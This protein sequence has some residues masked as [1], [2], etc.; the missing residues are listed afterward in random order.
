MNKGRFEAFSDGVFAIAITLLV[1]EFRLPEPVAGRPEGGLVNALLALW[2][3]YL[4]FFASF[5]TIGI[6]W[7]NHHGLFHSV[8]RVTH[9]I[10]LYNLLLLMLVAFVPFPT[11][12]LARYGPSQSA[13]VFYGFS[14]LLIA[15]AYR[16]LWY[17]VT[18]PPNGRHTFAGFVSAWT[19]W[20]AVGHVA[21]VAGIAIAFVSPIVSLCIFALVAIYYALSGTVRSVMREHP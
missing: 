2:P 17:V 6:M 14:L 18:P 10:L 19:P 9:A 3:Q 7:L 11:E 16:A 1:L 21:Y 8:A 4:V 15:I 12:V 5:A 13:V 20:T